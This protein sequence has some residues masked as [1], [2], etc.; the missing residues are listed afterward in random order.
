MKTIINRILCL[1]IILIVGVISNSCKD[2]YLDFKPV[3]SVND[4]S[5]YTTM[6]QAE[7]AVTAA[8][9]TLSTRTAWERDIVLYLGE[10]PSNDAEA[11][12]DYENEVPEVEEFN[13]FTFTPSSGVIENTYGVLYRGIY[14]SNLAMERIPNVLEEDPSASAAIINK[15]IG[16]L[17]FLRALNYMYLT[18][19]FGEVPL[20]DHTLLPEEY[21]MDVSTIREIFDLIEKDLNEAIPVLPERDELAANDVGRATKGA[22]K[23]LLAKMYLFESSYAR[24]YPGDSRFEGLTAKWGDVLSVCEDIIASDKYEL[25][26]IDGSTF[27]TWISPT[28]N[29]YRYIFTV[30]G[31]NSKEC[32]FSIQLINDGVD[33]TL[34][35][36][37][38]LVQWTSARYYDNDGTQTATSY[39]GLGWPTQSLVDEYEADDI[40]LHSNISMQ[41]DSIQLASGN[42]GL[43]DFTET[44]T[45]YYIKKF[46]LSREQFAGAPGHGW[47]KSPYNTI[48]LRYADVYLMAAEAAIML[49]NNDKALQYINQVRT[50]ARMSGNGTVPAD[51]TGTVTIEQLISERRKE[52]ALEGHRFFDLVRW[53]LAESVLKDTYTPGESFPIRFESPKNDFLPLPQREIITN[54]GALTQ[55]D[56]W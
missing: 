43:V 41:G 42:N 47:Q 36:A 11:G 52:L 8:Y 3:A 15:R 14:F 37:G 49:N 27:D 28:T 29:A 4:A 34:T 2:D 31:E 32:I 51:L 38:S 17:K 25:I 33:Y 6:N 22:A 20:V 48:L 12:G 13:R 24:Y 9:S 46:E 54:Q 16:E 30:D 26:G 53:K 18:M 39:W 10:V 50:R 21:F 5:F 40:R 1:S 19:I 35:R 56:G 23:A 55:H 45:G 7:Q 44:A